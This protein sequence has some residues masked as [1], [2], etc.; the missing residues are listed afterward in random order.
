MGRLDSSKSVRFYLDGV[1]GA[2]CSTDH[3]DSDE[4]NVGLV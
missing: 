4:Y 2:Q 1:R 3:T